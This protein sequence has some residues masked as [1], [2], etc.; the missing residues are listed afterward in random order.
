MRTFTGRRRLLL[1]G[2]LGAS[3]LVGTGTALAVSSGG[4]GGSPFW[5]DV[6]HRLGVTPTRLQTAMQQAMA[7]RLDAL[8]KQG[9]LTRAQA[10]AIEKRMQQHPGGPLMGPGW[11]GDR[12]GPPMFPHRGLRGRPFGGPGF[13]HPG[14]IGGT[15]QAAATYLGVPIRTLLS[16]LRSGKPLASVAQAQGKSVTGLEQAMIHAATSQL[17]AAVKAGHLTTAQRDT[18]VPEL[19]A[20]LKDF[21]EH[22]FQWRHDDEGGRGLGMGMGMGWGAAPAA[23][24]GV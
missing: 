20:G 1:V 4:N 19:S 24:S 5:N 23:G 12:L 13:M 6:A 16:D 18:I 8:V 21:V 17:D 22:G 3:A 10:D 15:L 11:D 2:A 14:P 7:D 9:A